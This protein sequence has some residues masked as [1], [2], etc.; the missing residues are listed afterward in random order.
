[1]APKVAIVYYSMY[2]HIAK[3]ANAEKEGIESAGGKVDLYQLPETLSE[4]VLKMMHAPPKDSNIPT[5][6]DPDTLAGYDGFLMGI[7]TRFGNFPDQWKAFWDKTGKQWQTGG[8]W[9][10]HAGLF[11]GTASQGGG[12]ESTAVAV[13]STLAHQGIIYVP[14]GYAKCFGDLVDLGEVRGGSAWGAGTFSGSDGSRMPTEKELRIAKTQ[15]EW[16]Y[17]T[18]AKAHA[19]RTGEDNAKSPTEPSQQAQPSGQDPQTSGPP[20]A[21]EST[22]EKKSALNCL[23]KDIKCVVQ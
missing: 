3:M 22:E 10:K 2:G 7:P 14:L 4:D 9:G 19:S 23:P 11:V 21:Q 1:M 13:M 18:V 17:K 15:G 5:L 16:F 6:H 12:Q 20:Q 8:F